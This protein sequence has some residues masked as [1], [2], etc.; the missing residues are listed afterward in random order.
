[1]YPEVKDGLF[2]VTTLNSFALIMFSETDV[3]L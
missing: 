2:K 3:S 1:M